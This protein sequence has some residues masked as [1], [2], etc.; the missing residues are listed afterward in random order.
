VINKRF[1]V[2]LGMFLSSYAPAA[3]QT[4]APPIVPAQERDAPI[5]TMLRT[6]STPLSAPSFRLA[7][8]HGQSPPRSSLL[9]AGAYERDHSLQPLPP[10]EEV[11]NLIHTLSSLPLVQLWGGRLQLDAFQNT[12]HS[13]NVQLGPLGYG[14]MQGFHPSAQSYPGGPRSTR[15]SLS[16]DFGRDGRTERPTQAWRSLSRIVGTVLD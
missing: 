11:K 10:M 2:L 13:Q 1:I 9:F 7:Q 15:I 5:I 3:A 14:G 8:D 6:V 16:F 12:P 4:P